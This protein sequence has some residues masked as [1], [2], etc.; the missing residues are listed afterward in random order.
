M[1]LRSVCD[2][3]VL[4]ANAAPI[5]DARV[6]QSL[7][8]THFEGAENPSSNYLFN[9]IL[10]LSGRARLVCH[11][12]GPCDPN[13]TSLTSETFRDI[14]KLSVKVEDSILLFP[15]SSL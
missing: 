7:I 2:V 12:A 8:K 14:S 13:S 11:C 9:N 5:S 15:M 1:C 3:C 10:I 4:P 6:S